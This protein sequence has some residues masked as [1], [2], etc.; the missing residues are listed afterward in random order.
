MAKQRRTKPSRGKRKVIREKSTRAEQHGLPAK[1]LERPSKPAPSPS[2]P[3]LAVR[4]RRRREE[5]DELEEEERDDEERES[6]PEARSRKGGVPALLDKIR[7]LPPLIKVGAVV[8][9]VLAGLYIAARI[10]QKSE[11]SASP[12]RAPTAEPAPPPP[13]IE[14]PT[15][16][17][18]PPQPTEIA[19]PPSA[20]PTAAESAPAPATSASAAPKKPK[21]KLKPPAAPAP[22]ATAGDN[23]Y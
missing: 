12:E 20:A 8:L 15:T 23:P 16:Q 10:R 3:P 14:E 21:P 22:T 1:K 13:T 9:V 4:R 17:V 6:D 2:Q 11:T 7:E 18:P 19:L 5:D